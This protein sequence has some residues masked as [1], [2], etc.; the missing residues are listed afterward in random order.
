M[1]GL[2]INTDRIVLIIV[3]LKIPKVSK[4]GLE[5]ELQNMFTILKKKIA[6]AMNGTFQMMALKQH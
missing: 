2:N 1:T 5:I 6:L 4:T 3:K